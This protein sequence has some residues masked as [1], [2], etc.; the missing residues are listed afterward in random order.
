MI[1][2]PTELVPQEQ[3]TTLTA[4]TTVVADPQLGRVARYLQGQLAAATG[5]ELPLLGAH[6]GTAPPGDPV[7]RLREEAQQQDDLGLEGYRLTVD[8]HGVEI[9]A[10]APAGAFYGVQTLRLLLPPAAVRQAPVV[11][12]VEWPLAGV[13]ITD[14]PRFGWRGVHIDL[15]RHLMP[16][17]WLLRLVELAALHKLNHLHLH[18]T[19]DQGWRFPVERY[20]R[21]TEV[22]AW[23]RET[24]AGHAD[25]GRYDGTPYGGHYSKDD[26]RELVAY[27]AERFITVLPEIDMPGHMVAAISAYPELGTTGRQ[28]EVGRTWGIEEEVLNVE[29]S[30]VRFCTDVLDEA[31]DIF[32]G[33]YVHVGGDECPKAA[34]RSSPRVQVLK[35]ERGLADEKE[36]QSWFLRKVAEHL[37]ERGR[38]LVGWDEI[39]DG[40]LPPDGV[41]MSWRGEQG[42]VAAALAGHDVIMT[43]ESHTYLDW[44]QSEDPAEPLAIRR[45]VDLAK[46]YGYEPL[47]AALPP[48]RHHHVLGSQAQLWTEY[49]RTPEHA[50]YMY[51]PRLCAFAEAVWSSGSRD[52]ADFE[53]RLR[54]HLSHLDALAVNYRPLTGPTP[55]QSAVWRSPV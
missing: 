45:S 50:E 3:G 19:D 23:R 31:L 16:L 11:G 21:L 8:E 9:V 17:P 2:R 30:T 55:G 18:L 39:L 1:P 20:P 51:F 38:T 26:L 32:P 24:M 33:K 15:A 37:R 5:W 54:D 40:G 46:V 29:E 27:A 44:Y 34:W 36:M 43:P 10:A 7:L 53:D 42:G 41:V 13:R 12:D 47:P 49:V 22:G 28:V 25:E 4:V 6:E 14:R 35:H 52:F 48:E